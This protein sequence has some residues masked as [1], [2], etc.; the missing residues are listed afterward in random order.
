MIGHPDIALEVLDD[1]AL[2]ERVQAGDNGAFDELAERYSARLHGMLYRI[3]GDDETC[4]DAAQEAL[5]RAWQ[6]I[7]R[8]EGR[9]RFS[10]WLTRIGIN[11]A[12]RILRRRREE[13]L[14]AEELAAFEVPDRR[15]RPDAVFESSEF[16]AATAAAL[17]ELRPSHRTAVRLRDVEGLSTS[18]AA[19]ALGISE[20]ALKSLLHRG[21]MALRAELEDYLAE[22]YL[23]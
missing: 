23:G 9:S 22:G 7:D 21:R 6:N 2:V 1:D 19:E 10:T 8:F 13:S 12:Y 5:A 11:E 18:E 14:D 16:L 4:S 15:R 17:A 3:T 20:G